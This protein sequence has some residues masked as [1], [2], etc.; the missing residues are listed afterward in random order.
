MPVHYNRHSSFIVY[1]LDSLPGLHDPMD[2]KDTLGDVIMDDP[3]VWGH[4]SVEVVMQGTAKHRG[5]DCGV[6]LILRQ[7]RQLKNYNQ[8]SEF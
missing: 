6:H 5:L 7:W 8:R 2:I 4:K 1:H 3:T